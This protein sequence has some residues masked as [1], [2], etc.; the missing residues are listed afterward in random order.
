MNTGNT[1]QV[2]WKDSEP[3]S[4]TDGTLVSGG[5]PQMEAGTPRC[6]RGTR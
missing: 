2:Y 6:S 4:V 5:S 3:T 1:Q